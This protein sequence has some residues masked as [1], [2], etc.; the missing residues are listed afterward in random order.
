MNKGRI[1]EVDNQIDNAILNYEESLK[2]DKGNVKT[3]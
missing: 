3:I 1:Y 2:M